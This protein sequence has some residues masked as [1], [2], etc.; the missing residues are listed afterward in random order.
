MS[1][2]GKSSHVAP[3]D[4]QCVFYANNLTAGVTVVCIRGIIT[5]FIPNSRPLSCVPFVEK[6]K[7]KLVNHCA[8]IVTVSS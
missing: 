3:D 2:R 5:L 4:V 1:Y 8:Y 7:L 6:T